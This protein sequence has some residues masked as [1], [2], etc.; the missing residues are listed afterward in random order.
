MRIVFLILRVSCYRSLCLLAEN[1]LSRPDAQIS[2]VLAP[3]SKSTSL[4][5]YQDP[6]AET[7]PLSLRET[8]VSH[9]ATYQEL[10]TRL[11]QADVVVSITGPGYFLS[12]VANRYPDYSDDKADRL[13]AY[14]KNWAMVFDTTDS[15]FPSSDPCGADIVFWPSLGALENA[16]ARHSLPSQKKRL[17]ATA[18]IVGYLRADYFAVTSRNELI[19]EHGLDPARP[20]VAWVPDNFVL[21]QDRAL[22]TSWFHYQWMEQSRIRRAFN[23]IRYLR[24]PLLA[25]KALYRRESDAGVC[26]AIHRFCVANNAQLVVIPRRLKD[27]P[28]SSRFTVLERNYAYLLLAENEGYPQAFMVGTAMADIVICCYRTAGIVDA[29]ARGVPTITVLAPDVAF[30]KIITD[31]HHW[32]DAFF[33]A[34]GFH[35]QIDSESFSSSFQNMLLSDFP[36]DPVSL[37]GF[38]ETHLGNCDGRAAQRI[39]DKILALA[40]ARGATAPDGEA[41]VG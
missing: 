37:K 1:L 21:K 38:R 2:L 33:R 3:P 39:S 16:C 18:H 15:G 23:A 22:V 8:P 41:D 6:T 5:S 10:L 30:T 27:S 12:A 31:Y 7:V 19:K 14:V 32:F 34:P 35:Y 40:P 13:V 24:N 29:A 26:R 9:P 4:K 25:L 36:L 28:G 17:C 11:A 20:I